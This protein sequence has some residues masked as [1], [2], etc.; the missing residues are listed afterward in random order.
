MMPGA[1]AA[2]AAKVS[3]DLDRVLH[4]K[5]RKKESR[6]N[7]MVVRPNKTC[8]GLSERERKA[9][10]YRQTQIEGCFVNKFLLIPPRPCMP[11]FV[12]D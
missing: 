3:S 6:S 2:E 12:L 8:L 4:S 5:V 1:S 9:D 10:T 11:W 7:R